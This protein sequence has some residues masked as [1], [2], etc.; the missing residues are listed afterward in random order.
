M[1]TTLTGPSFNTGDTGWNNALGTLGHA[2]FP[3]PARQAQ[4]YYY[5]TEARNQILKGD[6]A[7]TE[8]NPAQRALAM[9]MA[10]ERLGATPSAPT[11]RP[12]GLPGGAP[13]LNPPNTSTDTYPTPPGQPGPDGPHPVALYQTYGEGS[14]TNPK[15]LLT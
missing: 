8:A 11:Y 1:G 14:T 5:G 6:T 9:Q 3:D 7:I 2:L 15:G 4:A 13:I 10:L 12:S